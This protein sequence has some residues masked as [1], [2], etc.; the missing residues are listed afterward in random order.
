MV[1]KAS[2]TTR[3][4]RCFGI[5]HLEEYLLKRL[6]R[7]AST[8]ASFQFLFVVE[9]KGEAN[10]AAIDA[11]KALL[12]G[13]FIVGQ[14]EVTTTTFVILQIRWRGCLVGYF[15]RGEKGEGTMMTV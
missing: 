5:R 2:R 10:S 1:S 11:L 9:A 3:H 14:L 6:R 4:T 13:I 7:I 15:L 8:N 12:H